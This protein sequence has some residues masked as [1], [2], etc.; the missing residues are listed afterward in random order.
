NQVT[1]REFVC[2]HSPVYTLETAIQDQVYL[3]NKSYVAHDCVIGQGSVLSAGV[4]LGGRVVLEEGVTI[5][6]GTAVHQR[7]HIGAYAM[8]GMQTPVNRDILP[9]ATVAGN[10]AR[11]IG[12]NRIGAERKAYAENWMQEMEAFYKNDVQMGGGTD[13]PMIQLIHHFLLAHPEALVRVRN[14]GD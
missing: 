10:P 11:I 9:F 12:F 3:M 4:L 8:I 7:C 2:I 13:N 6:M 1:I 14:T 5:G